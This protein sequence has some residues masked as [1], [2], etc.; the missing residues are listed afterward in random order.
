MQKKTELQ[1]KLTP[2]LIYQIHKIYRIY[3]SNYILGT[4][5]LQ[6]IG[7]TKKLNKNTNSKTIL[8][9]KVLK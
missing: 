5:S 9:R 8:Q 7:K 1:E 3:V 4:V 2:I 6:K